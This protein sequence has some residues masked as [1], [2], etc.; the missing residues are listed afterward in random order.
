[1]GDAATPR[2]GQPVN[3]GRGDPDFTF[4]SMVWMRWKKAFILENAS[5]DGNSQGTGSSSF[6][7]RERERERQRE[8]RLSLPQT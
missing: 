8:R 3:G 1:M 2:G 7:E 4:T 6:K 5:E